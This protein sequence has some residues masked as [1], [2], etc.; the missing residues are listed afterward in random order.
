MRPVA[1]IVLA[2]S[3]FLVLELP[4]SAPARAVIVSQSTPHPVRHWVV[5]NQ[6]RQPLTPYGSG[7]RGID[8]EVKNGEVIHAPF[9]AKVYWRGWVGTRFTVALVRLDGLIFEAEP[10]CS[11]LAT[12]ADALAGATVGRV[13]ESPTYVSHCA[14]R[15]CAHLGLRTSLGYFSLESF[16]GELTPSRLVA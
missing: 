2:G 16:F 6:F 11:R 3:L 10:V 9:A 14:P 12:G 7:H 13:C 15:L 4:S 1:A 8:V 5:M